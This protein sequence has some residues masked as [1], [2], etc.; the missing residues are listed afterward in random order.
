MLRS[1]HCILGIPVHTAGGKNAGDEDVLVWSVWTS[2]WNL[3]RL[4][5]VEAPSRGGLTIIVAAMHEHARRIHGVGQISYAYR[6]H[7]LKISASVNVEDTWEGG[8]WNDVTDAL[9]KRLRVHRR[10]GSAARARSSSLV[11]LGCTSCSSCSSYDF[12]DL[13]CLAY[14]FGE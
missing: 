8:C 11:Q 3:V 14:G 4:C 12:A 7:A 1:L 10:S 13:Y 5:D 6:L 9:N 2:V